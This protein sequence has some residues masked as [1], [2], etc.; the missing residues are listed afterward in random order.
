MHNITFD[1]SNLHSHGAAFYD[2]LAL[3]KKVFVDELKWDIP[4]NDSVEMDQ[5]DTPIAQYSLVMYQG[6]VVGGA[7]AM[8][9]SSTWGD[10]TYMLR[11]AQ[12]GKLPKIPAE[13]MTEDIASPA[14]WE[15]TRLVISN[16]LTTQKERSECLSLIVDGLVDL[17]VENGASRLICLSSLALMRALRQIGYDVTRLGKTYR[18]ADDG[19]TYAVLG[20][21][22]THSYHHLH[23]MQQAVPFQLSA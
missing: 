21:P 4:H 14:V 20:M 16:D 1:F 9:T 17:A 3:R 10:H 19:R 18:N 7:R 22:A 8:A 12:S 15:C 6:K 5:Y 2:Y 13:L 23:A 11:D